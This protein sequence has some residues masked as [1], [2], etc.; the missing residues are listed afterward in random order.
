M[1]KK[2]HITARNVFVHEI[3]GL[4]AKVVNSSDKNRIGLQGKIVDETMKTLRIETAKGEK[5]VPKRE[6]V[7]ELELLNGEKVLVDGKN[8]EKRPEDRTKELWRKSL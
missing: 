6:V 1:E 5:I 8:I 7:F 3:I 4:K 2:Y